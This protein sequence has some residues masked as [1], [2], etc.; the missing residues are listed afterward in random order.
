MDGIQ[1]IRCIWPGNNVF[2][3]TIYWAK[4]AKQCGVAVTTAEKKNMGQTARN[5][6]RNP[7]AHPTKKKTQKPERNTDNFD[8][9]VAKRSH[10][11]YVEN[12]TDPTC[13]K[14]LLPITTE[15]KFT[16][17]PQ[18]IILF[19]CDFYISPLSKTCTTLR[20]HNFS[21][22]YNQCNWMT[23]FMKC[24]LAKLPHNK[25]NM[26]YNLESTGEWTAKY[27]TQTII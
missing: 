19:P 13:K 1:N 17:N 16:K 10:W 4:M 14:M 22:V 27:I 5:K 24:L 21:F 20:T 11:L 23:I 18:K 12:K 15:N 3:W 6:W 7:S 25:P 26:P 9:H 2:K 8:L